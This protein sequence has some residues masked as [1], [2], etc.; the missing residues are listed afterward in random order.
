MART[1][2][3]G[4][5][6]RCGRTLASTSIRERITATHYDR[7]GVSPSASTEEVRA[8][9]RALARRLHPDRLVDASEAERA[10][11]ERRMREINQAWRE[12]R[13]PP[14]RR[15]Y[16]DDRLARP[17][18]SSGSSTRSAS[19]GGHLRGDGRSALDHAEDDDL[20][21]VLPPMTAFT[22]GVMRH[23]PWVALV[24]VFGLLFVVSA[25]A[26]AK[27]PEPVHT[28][29]AT[30]GSCIDVRPGPATTVVPCSGDH[31]L[32]IVRRVVEVAA[33]PARTEPRRLGVDRLIDC[34]VPG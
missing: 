18:R 25:Y 28:G 34:V 2:E 14:S 26:R 17:R 19:S 9:Y 33:C 8:A 5:P 15:R 22:A 16:D 21:E 4:S 27:D 6:A 30:A 10:L 13:D 20:V 32:R 23:L 1:R 24:V 11:A 7:L 29:R 31:D 12:L 3:L